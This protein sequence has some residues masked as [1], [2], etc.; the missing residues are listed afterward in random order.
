MS[1]DRPQYEG[2]DENVP[3]LENVRVLEGGIEAAG[4]RVGIVATRW[5]E[6]VI[7]GLLQGA[8]ETLAECQVANSDVTVI[9]VP[10]AFEVPIT[11]DRAAATGQF[12]VLVALACVVRGDTPHF[13]YVAGACTDGVV[14]VVHKHEIPIAFGVLTTDN[15]QQAEVRAVAGP[16][17]KGREA[18]HAVLQTWNT[19]RLLTA[20]EL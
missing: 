4:A 19:I 17:N 1:T 6:G 7:N 13:D 16:E 2:G 18:V 14:A 3:A 10:G 9:R 5:N 8:L 15:Q 11:L 20:N 12:D